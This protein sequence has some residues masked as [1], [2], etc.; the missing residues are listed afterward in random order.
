MSSIILQANQFKAIYNSNA[1]LFKSKYI[2]T[3]SSFTNKTNTSIVYRSKLFREEQEKKIAVNAK[4]VHKTFCKVCQDA[5]KSEQEYTNHSV[6]DKSGKTVCPTLLSQ[7]CRNCG[8]NGHTVKYCSLLKEPVKRAPAPAPVQKQAYKPTNV[9]MLLESDSEEECECRV[10]ERE[11][12][13]GPTIAP[14]LFAFQKSALNYRK[15]IEQVNDPES[16]AKAKREEI[17]AKRQA[18]LVKW[19]KI[20][21]AAEVDREAREQRLKSI[22]KTRWIDAESSDE[23]DEDEEKEVVDNSAW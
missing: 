17:E 8:E 21:A 19:A 11:L 14:A 2:I 4:P 18:D 5:G 10:E 22:K 23:E 7:R 9:F 20:Q 1:I 13:V 15:I 3:M 12:V 6:R 16:Y